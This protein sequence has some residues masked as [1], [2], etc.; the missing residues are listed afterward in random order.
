M[1]A[2]SR[3]GGGRANADRS[4]AE[5]GTVAQDISGK[6]LERLGGGGLEVKSEKSEGNP[7]VHLQNSE[8]TMT[9]GLESSC[10]GNFLP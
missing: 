4:P 7:G 5:N 10:P 2:G 8:L 1:G 6:S 9:C 3:G